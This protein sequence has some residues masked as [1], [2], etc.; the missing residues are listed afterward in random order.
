MCLSQWC[1]TGWLFCSIHY[2]YPVFLPA[3]VV[4]FLL[5]CCSQHFR[6]IVKPSLAFC[7]FQLF[8]INAGILII[9]VTKFSWPTCPHV[10]SVCAGPRDHVTSGTKSVCGTCACACLCTCVP[11]IKLAKEAPQQS[12]VACTRAFTLLCSKLTIGVC[13][14]SLLSLYCW[15]PSLICMAWVVLCCILVLLN[16]M[17][18]TCCVF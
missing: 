1:G 15:V 2:T 17:H 12:S 4:M 16:L 14:V 3:N 10:S 18:M 8:H 7:A 6:T 13:I 11:L 9:S 5:T